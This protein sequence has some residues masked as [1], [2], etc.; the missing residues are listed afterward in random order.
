MRSSEILH[1]MSLLVLVT[2]AQ[3]VGV[4]SAQKP[5]EITRGIPWFIGMIIVVIVVAVAAGL[6]Q[7]KK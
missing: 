4:A 6:R 3:C 2:I 1:M 7:K 5:E